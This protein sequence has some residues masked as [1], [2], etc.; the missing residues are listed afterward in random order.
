MEVLYIR[1]FFQNI[2]SIVVLFLKENASNLEHGKLGKLYID[3]SN[4]K[5]QMYDTTIELKKYGL[6]G[7]ENK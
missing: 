6:I 1:T 3:T 7:K 4:G 5:K 2:W